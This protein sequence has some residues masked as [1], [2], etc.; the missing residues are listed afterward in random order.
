MG[1][2]FATSVDLKTWASKYE[3]DDAGNTLNLITNFR[4]VKNKVGPPQQE[5]NFRVWLRDYDGHKVGDVEDVSVVLGQ[6]LKHK[7]FGEYDNEQE[8]FGVTEGKEFKKGKGK[9][10]EVEF[11]SVDEIFKYFKDNPDDYETLRTSLFA[12]MLGKI[13]SDEDAMQVSADAGDDDDGEVPEKVLGE[14]E[15]EE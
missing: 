3:K 8:A 1:Q 12:D 2:E 9:Y 7:W 4:A 11:E 15:K 6:A 5:G 10:K 13:M 14:G